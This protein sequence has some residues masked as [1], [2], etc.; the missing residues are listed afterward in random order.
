LIWPMPERMR[1]CNLCLTAPGESP[2]LLQVSSL[3]YLGTAV[4]AL[5]ARGPGP[6]AL[7]ASVAC[8]SFLYHTFQENLPRSKCLSFYRCADI[9]LACVASFVVL[10]ECCTIDKNSMNTTAI[11]TLSLLTAISFITSGCENSTF[12]IQPFLILGAA[13]T[14]PDVLREKSVMKKVGWGVGASGAL[15]FALGD[16][17]PS[18]CKSHSMW[19]LLTAL[20]G[21]IV[22]ASSIIEARG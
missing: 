3:A 15:A 9:L 10:S 1:S 7:Y 17:L 6:A 4:M 21:G 20:G 16:Q 8:M 22:Y 5:M 19:H 12:I 13:Y 11:I 14:L 18:A 2:F